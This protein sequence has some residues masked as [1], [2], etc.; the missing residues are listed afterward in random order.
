VIEP[1]VMKIVATVISH[2]VPVMEQ[3]PAVFKPSPAIITEI[4]PVAIFFIMIHTLPVVMH[5]PFIIPDIHPV[6]THIPVLSLR[7]SSEE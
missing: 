1:S 3:I 6:A 4:I 7:D 5:I 2:V